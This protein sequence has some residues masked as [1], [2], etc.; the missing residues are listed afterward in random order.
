MKL[1]KR[2]QLYYT[3][4]SLKKVSIVLLDLMMSKSIWEYRL[5]ERNYLDMLKNLQMELNGFLTQEDGE[6][7]N[8]VELF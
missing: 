6:F 4:R 5:I 7:G 3:M 1:D 8:R 2:R